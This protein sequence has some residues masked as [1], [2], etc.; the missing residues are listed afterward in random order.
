MGQNACNSYL[1]LPL[2]SS[3][4]FSD[5]E[6]KVIYVGSSESSDNDQILEEVLVGPVSSGCHK[7][8]LQADAPD[9]SQLHDGILGVTVVL[10]TC[11]YRDH[12]FVRIGYYVNNSQEE[13]E[14]ALMRTEDYLEAGSNIDPSKVIRT[15]LA[16]KPR[17]TRF[18][19]PWEERHVE[20]LNE[21]S[22]IISSPI[23]CKKPAENDGYRRIVS[24]MEDSIMEE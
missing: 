3:F 22:P 20:Q 14:N 6:W 19:I 12:E 15:T 5:L 9:V 1:F 21:M 4:P 8:V 7:F 2:E 10:I 18:C 17:V 13:E 16:D 23:P 11:S 24:P